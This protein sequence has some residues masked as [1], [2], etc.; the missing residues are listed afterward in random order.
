[1]FRRIFGD[2]KENKEKLGSKKFAVS[3]ERSNRTG[4]AELTSLDVPVGS[5]SQIPPA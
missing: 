2:Y 3:E 5:W 4:A 1:M